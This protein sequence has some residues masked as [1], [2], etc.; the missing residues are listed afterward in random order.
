MQKLSK[1]QMLS[2][3]MIKLEIIDSKLDK[4][5]GVVR[6]PEV[7]VFMESNETIQGPPKPFFD[8]SGS[9]LYSCQDVTPHCIDGTGPCKC[10]GVMTNQEFDEERK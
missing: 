1:E 5:L 2:E 3:L 6:I 4:L 9:K 7:K 8:L 10:S